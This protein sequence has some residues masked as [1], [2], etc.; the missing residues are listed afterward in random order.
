M[1]YLEIIINSAKDSISATLAERSFSHRVL[2]RPLFM[3]GKI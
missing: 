2:P 1:N 3:N